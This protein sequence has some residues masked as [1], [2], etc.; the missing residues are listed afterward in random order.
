MDTFHENLQSQNYDELP[1]YVT[2]NPKI[3]HLQLQLNKLTKLPENFINLSNLRS[4]DLSYNKFTNFPNEILQLTNLEVL[5]LS[6]NPL[7]KIPKEISNLKKLKHLELSSNELDS[8]PLE[9]GQLI[10]L[11]YLHLRYNNLKI[12]PEG[13]TNLCNLEELNITDNKLEYIPKEIGKLNKLKRFEL[14]DNKLIELPNKIG[15]LSSL[16]FFIAERN[17]LKAIPDE[18][19]NIE[20]LSS[21]YLNDNPIQ[22]IPH[23]LIEKK[24]NRLLW[25]DCNSLNIYWDK[26]D[27]EKV[28]INNNN[29]KISQK[30]IQLLPQELDSDEVVL[31]FYDGKIT[32][33]YNINH[34]FESLIH[35]DE[36]SNGIMMAIDIVLDIINK[37]NYKEV[38]TICNNPSNYRSM[39]NLIFILPVT[40]EQKDQFLQSEKLSFIMEN[41][42]RNLIKFDNQPDYFYESNISYFQLIDFKQITF[43]FPDF[44]KNSIGV[45]GNETL[46]IFN[47]TCLGGFFDYN[48][49]E[50]IINKNF[51]IPEIEQAVIF[52]YGHRGKLE[53]IDFAKGFFLQNNLAKVDNHLVC[54]THPLS[55]SLNEVDAV[56]FSQN[57][58]AKTIS[59]ITTDS[60]PYLQVIGNLRLSIENK[61][62]LSIDVYNDGLAYY[63]DEAQKHFGAR[64]IAMLEIERSKSN[65]NKQNTINF[66]YDEGIYILNVALIKKTG[67]I[68]ND[69]MVNPFGFYKFLKS[70]HNPIII[71][72]D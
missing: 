60:N 51:S 71:M 27:A 16:E 48:K 2:M 23:R 29:I 69:Y 40:K 24:N 37:L 32:F 65:E 20:S 61:Y 54:Y 21:L 1:E 66:N 63:F 43:L 46:T 53:E 41:V 26:Y 56:K 8:L 28:L 10:N 42:F 44:N 14:C 19:A 47:D 57:V 38:I 64:S 70:L 35:Y 12:F 68:I 11:T 30:I 4:L 58:G 52:C 34:D 17:N 49:R 6:G 7:K 62:N 22:K 18:L 9:I 5:I 31:N 13:I 55:S 36:I 67:V 45:P 25:M 15:E 59:S 33:V 72:L 50:F 39:F 3:T